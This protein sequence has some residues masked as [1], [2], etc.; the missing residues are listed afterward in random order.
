MNYHPLTEDMRMYFANTYIVRQKNGETQVLWVDHTVRIGDDTKLD[1]FEF[2]G[3]MY[4]TEGHQADD[5]HFRGDE[6]IE[7]RPTSGYYSLP[8]KRGRQYV[9]FHVQ[10]RTQRKGLNP[11][12]CT[13][14]GRAADLRGSDVAAMFDQT[15][16]MLSNPALRDINVVNK[17]VHWRGYE[18]GEIKDNVFAAAEEF[19]HLEGMVCR[20][21]QNI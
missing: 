21:L 6:M 13:V 9:Q 1:G 8:G 16:A 10:N 12:G 5:V 2:V 18:V 11:G 7:W 17:K 19:N 14:N 15:A 3:V 4:T 20:L